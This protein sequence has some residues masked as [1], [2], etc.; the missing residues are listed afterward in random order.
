MQDNQPKTGTIALK[1]GAILGIIGI[2]FNLML[3]SQ[4]LHYQIDLQRILFTIGLGL[5]FIV[6]GSIIGI[7][8]FKKQN[9]GYVSFGE[10]LKIGIGMALIS[11]SSASYSVSY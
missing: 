11:G 1:Y 6:V 10:G 7:K 5:V 3:Y 4:D 9:D 8:E 2:V